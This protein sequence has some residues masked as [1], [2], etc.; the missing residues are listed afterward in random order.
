[1]L[2]A[3]NHEDRTQGRERRR[4]QTCGEHASCSPGAGQRCRFKLTCLEGQTMLITAHSPR[5]L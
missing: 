3:L 2:D 4:A 5:A 1:M